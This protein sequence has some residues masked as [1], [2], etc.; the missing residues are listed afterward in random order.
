MRAFKIIYR[1]SGFLFLIGFGRL[2]LAQLRIYPLEGKCQPNG[3][4]AALFI[5]LILIS[6]SIFFI[7]IPKIFKS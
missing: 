6:I 2:L 5:T 4:T 3:D 7:F 1:T